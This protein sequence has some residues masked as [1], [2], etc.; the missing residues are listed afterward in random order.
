MM[1]YLG[2]FHRILEGG[3]CYG[4]GGNGK[5]WLEGS[6]SISIDDKKR[7]ENSKEEFINE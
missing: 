1:A 6:T 3:D 2:C 7:I 5:G 4:D